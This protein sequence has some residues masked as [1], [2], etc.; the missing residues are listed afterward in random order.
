MRAAPNAPAPDDTQAFAGSRV[1]EITSASRRAKNRSMHLPDRIPWCAPRSTTKCRSNGTELA[2]TCDRSPR[3]AG[4]WR[5]KAAVDGLDHFADRDRAH[6]ASKT[7]PSLRSSTGKVPRDALQTDSM[8]HDLLR[9]HGY[10]VN[11]EELVSRRT[12]TD[13]VLGRTVVSSG[14]LPLSQRLRHGRGTPRDVTLLPY[15]ADTWSTG[16]VRSRR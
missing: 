15:P 4:L 10:A 9:E 6:P 7:S 1:Q 2:H 8:K 12:S 13:R 3:S 11:L 16:K 5:E 14:K